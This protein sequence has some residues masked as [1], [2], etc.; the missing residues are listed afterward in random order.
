MGTKRAS[1]GISIL[2]AA[3]L[4]LALM[5]AACSQPPV[6]SPFDGRS[7]LYYVDP[8]LPQPDTYPD[9]ARV[10][11]DS[12]QATTSAT[13][14]YATE[15]DFLNYLALRPDLVVYIRQASAG[16]PA[17]H[18]AALLDWIAGGG[19]LVFTHYEYSGQ[20]AQTL[21][22]ALQ[23][24]FNTVYNYSGLHVP[25]GSALASGLNPTSFDFYSTGWGQNNVGLVASGGAGVASFATTD[26]PAIVRGNGGRTYHLGFMSDTLP[27][28]NGP[29]LY[30]NIFAAALRTL[31]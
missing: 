17:G 6:T 25:P 28:A 22:A 15:G 27:A 26:V 30:T 7:I 11:L 23:S 24:G 21:A 9:M 1:A 12:I 13:V 2:L 10:S 16:F 19:L 31:P 5:L 18:Q 8:Y 14:I 3:S 20:A 4:T 29:R